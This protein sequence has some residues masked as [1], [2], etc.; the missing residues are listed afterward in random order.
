MISVAQL[1]DLALNQ[2]AIL[3][4]SMQFPESEQAMDEMVLDGG[5][6]K[7]L[8]SL[9]HLLRSHSPGGVLVMVERPIL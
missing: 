1:G 8:A 9:R 3:H 7:R 6:N 5:M 4:G 2:E